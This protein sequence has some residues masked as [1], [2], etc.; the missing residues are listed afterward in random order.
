MPEDYAARLVAAALEQT[1]TSV[2]YD[3]FAY[4][5]TGHYRYVAQ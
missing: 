5:I 1:R 3:G 4:P 2:T